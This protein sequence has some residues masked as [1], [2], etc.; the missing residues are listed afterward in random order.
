MKF[1]IAVLTL[2]ALHTHAHAEEL[3]QSQ[4]SWDGG[5]FAYPQG[6]PEISSYKLELA[7][8]AATPEHCH[9]VPTMGYVL[10]GRLRVE[11]AH[12]DK[13]HFEAGQSVVEVM[14]TP[15]VGTAVEGPVEI[16]VFYAGDTNTPNTVLA[17]DDSYARYCQSDG[18]TQ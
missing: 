7:T 6:T 8:G 13:T 1:F 10:S 18:A 15:H 12:N 17:T 5:A 2:F 14:R 4:Q 11:T 3:L 9:P 16:V